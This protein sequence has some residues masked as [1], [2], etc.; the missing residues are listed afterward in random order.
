MSELFGS[1]NEVYSHNNTLQ[2]DLAL[3]KFWVALCGW[4]WLC[5]N[6][7]MGIKITNCWKMFGYGVKMTTT[8]CLSASG[9]SWNE[10]LL[11][12]LVIISQQKKS[13]S[14]REYTFPR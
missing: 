1:V 2:L 6:V 7:Y 14:G 9:N 12:D 11:I 8:K 5:T 4:L 10:L 3:E 13:E